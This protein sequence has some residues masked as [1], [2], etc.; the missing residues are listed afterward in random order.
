M[1]RLEDL[2]KDKVAIGK[3]SNTHGLG[4]EL[5]LFPYTNEKKIFNNLTDVLLYNPKTKRFLYAKLD[6]I[7]KADKIYIIS[8]SGVENISSAQRYKDF[9]V[10]IPKEKLPILDNSEFYYFE[11]LE[12]EVLY[13]DGESVGKIVDILETGA[14]EVLIIEKQIDRFNKE[15]ILY[16]LIKENLIKFTKEDDNIV[17]KR[18]EWYEDDTED[19]D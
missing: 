9:I 7:R 5:K 4:G 2:L 3:I 11:L 14:N 6:S 10:Y 8:I 18:L 16:P 13:E 17:V 12:K 1:K 15:E 19:R